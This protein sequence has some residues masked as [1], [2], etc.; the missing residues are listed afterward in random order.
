MVPVRGKRS[1]AGIYAALLQDRQLLD[2]SHYLV[3]PSSDLAENVATDRIP[4]LG[5]F[6]R[7]AGEALVR[8]QR[9]VGGSYGYNLGYVENG[10]HQAPKYEGRSHYVLMTDA[11]AT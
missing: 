3:C 1:T 7:A 6:D 8:L 2:N 4:T 10:R 5:E 11:P 9:T